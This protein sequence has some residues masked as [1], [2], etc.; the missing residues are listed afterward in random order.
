MANEMMTR[1]L[2]VGGASV[3]WYGK[4]GEGVEGGRWTGFFNF[5]VFF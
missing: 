5:R 1:A 2:G 4:P 3:H